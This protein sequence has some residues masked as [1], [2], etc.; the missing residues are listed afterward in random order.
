MLK[1]TGTLVICHAGMSRSATVCIAYLMREDKLSY[2]AAFEEVKA[3]RRFIN[4]NQGFRQIL[5]KYETTL[6]ELCQLEKKTQ[7]FEEFAKCR[8]NILFKHLKDEFI[9]LLC[10]Q[11]DMPIVVFKHHS[12]EIHP[13]MYADL[14]LMISTFADKFYGPGNW[15]IDAMQRTIKTHWH[16]HIRKIDFDAHIPVFRTYGPSL[17]QPGDKKCLMIKGLGS[18]EE[19]KLASAQLIT[20]HGA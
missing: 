14:V 11:C 13:L 20:N 2:S 6:C 19:A 16:W 17:P 5:K 12:A 8:A 9:I 10:D 18:I 15:F 1:E 3:A 4:P 7:W